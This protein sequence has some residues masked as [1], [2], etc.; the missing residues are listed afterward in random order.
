MH[1]DSSN[2]ATLQPWLKAVYFK[3]YTPF[4]LFNIT[5]S[6]GFND[7]IQNLVDFLTVT[8]K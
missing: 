1:F 7:K 8:N 4:R 2:D 5:F 6:F 3:L